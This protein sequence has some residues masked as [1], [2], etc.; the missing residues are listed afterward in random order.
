M[1]HVAAAAEESDFDDTER[2]EP[3]RNRWGTRAHHGNGGSVS[4][5]STMGSSTTTPVNGIGSGRPWSTATTDTSG[6]SVGSTGRSAAERVVSGPWTSPAGKDQRSAFYSLSF[7][8]L[9]QK[10]LYA[11]EN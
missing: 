1:D 9:S 10:D 5:G 6:S 7:P 11:F 3:P 4:S 8:L 2:F